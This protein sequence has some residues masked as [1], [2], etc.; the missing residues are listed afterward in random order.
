MNTVKHSEQSF[1]FFPERDKR[2][3]LVAV[4]NNFYFY[5]CV[6]SAATPI[7]RYPNCKTMQTKEIIQ[8]IQRLP[9][10]KR[11]FVLEEIIKMLKKEELESKMDMAV[12]ELQADYQT[13]KELTSFTSIDFD[14]FYESR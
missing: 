7:Q 6:T 11:Y 9:L 10:S 5:Q 2:V 1:W 3:R 14:S 12:N 8:E 13:D 4:V